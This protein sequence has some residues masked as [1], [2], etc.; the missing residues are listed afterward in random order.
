MIAFPELTVKTRLGT[1]DLLPFL[2]RDAGQLGVVMYEWERRP[3]ALAL[4]ERGW[5]QE[6]IGGCTRRRPVRPSDPNDIYR[7]RLA[8][9]TVVN[10]RWYH[11][12]APHGRNGYT[13]FGCRCTTCT[14][15]SSAA[16]RAWGAKARERKRGSR[17]EAHDAN[18]S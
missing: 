4:H 11:P 17:Q 16:R 3:A 14:D 5:T 15:A 13:N 9:R 10:G 12:G 6:R 18:P 7:R 8:Q 1:V 2:R